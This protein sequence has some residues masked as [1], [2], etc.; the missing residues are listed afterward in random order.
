MVYA[1]AYRLKKHDARLLATCEEIAARPAPPAPAPAT[2]ATTPTGGA[3]PATP[4]GVGS[5]AEPAKDS[6]AGSKES[7]QM[8]IDASDSNAAV[9]PTEASQSQSQSESEEREEESKE[10]STPATTEKPRTALETA[11]VETSSAAAARELAPTPTAATTTTSTTTTTTEDGHVNVNGEEEEE[12]LKEKPTFVLDRY[13]PASLSEWC[14]GKLTTLR[15]CTFAGATR[16]RLERLGEE[17][18]IWTERFTVDSLH[19]LHAK[20]YQLIHQHRHEWD[21]TRLLEVRH[22]TSPFAHNHTTHS[23][24]RFWLCGTT[25]ADQGCSRAPTS[26]SVF[27]DL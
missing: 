2:T 3:T 26:L 19:A 21:K 18:V 17:V 20:V 1:F 23:P 27:G 5:A 4:S 6:E 11:P 22:I 13:G 14:T 16:E 9:K 24:Q 25:G 15:C 7:D 10:S 8:E 12:E